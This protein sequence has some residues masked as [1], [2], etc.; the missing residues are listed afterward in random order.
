MAKKKTT[1]RKHVTHNKTHIMLK[2]SLLVY[3]VLVFLF[4]ILI[5][6]SAF[7]LV[8]S[9]KIYHNNQRYHA[10]TSIYQNLGL[11][12]SYRHAGFDV[13]GEKRTYAWDDARSQSSSMSYGRNADR[14]AT[15]KDLQTKIEAAGFHKID[16][17][18]YGELARQDHYKNDQGQFIRVSIE[19]AA[20]H[21]A[22]LYGTAFPRPQSAE[23]NEQGPVYVTIKVNLDDNN[24]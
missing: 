22:M 5:T 20:W 1:P 23:A 18:N 10:I 11:D 15:F 12:E 16:G 14:S 17:P 24:E 2:K 4:F 8:E 6:L 13:F 9:N 19:T 3:A 21:E 7:A